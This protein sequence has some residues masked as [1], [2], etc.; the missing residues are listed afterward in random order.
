[1]IKGKLKK[2]EYGTLSQ[3]KFE[4]VKR[5]SRRKVMVFVIGGIT[6][7]EN[8][9]LQL[10]GK[11]EGFDAITGSNLIINSEKYDTIYL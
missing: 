6:Y 3:S 1:M 7:Q 9:E 11:R 2:A 10:A 5:N 8:R 4:D